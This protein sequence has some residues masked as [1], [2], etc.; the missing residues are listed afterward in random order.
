MMVDFVSVEMEAEL[1]APIR[2]GVMV[3][4]SDDGEVEWE[5]SAR[6]MVKGSFDSR[7][8]V[9]AISPER[10]EISGNLA[11]FMQGHN[12]FGP[13]DLPELLHAFL[14]RVQPILWPEGLPYI[15]VWGGKLSRVDC[16]SGLLLETPSDVLSYLL[17]A[18][19]RG[20]CSHRGRGVMKGQGT[21]VY[22]DATGKRAKAWQLTLYAKGLEVAKH[23]LPELMM[24][25]ADVL[26]YV[27]RLLRVE[28]RVRTAELNRMGLRTVEQWVPGS[29]ERVWREKVDRIEFMEGTV[30]AC[31]D[32]EGVKPRLLDA[33]D[34]W[35]AGR[36]MR[37]GRSSRVFYYLRKEMKDVFGV[38][39]S[40]KCPKSNVVPLRRVIVAEP[41]RRPPW[42]DEVQRLLAVA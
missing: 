39:I 28:V 41:A 21:L 1:P 25:R 19:E 37:Q 18:E 11:K 20:N 16:T 30:M 2:D 38:D 27:N 17:A 23:P 13:D 3:K 5:T 14:A 26:E 9:R 34:A 42:A 24:A 32:F 35:Q 40:I 33:Y 31:S 4:L 36:D 12:I 8:A 15:D 6:L 29:C 22:G 10:L 7:V